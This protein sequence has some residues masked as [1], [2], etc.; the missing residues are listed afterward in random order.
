M[1]AL[2]LSLRCT[3]LL[4]RTMHKVV[5][6]NISPM[7]IREI[8]LNEQKADGGDATDNAESSVV[9]DNESEGECDGQEAPENNQDDARRYSVT[10]AE[11]HFDGGRSVE[12]D[13]VIYSGLDD[14]EQEADEIESDGESSKESNWIESDKEMVF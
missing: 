13:D 12:E 2:E 4:M 6:T 10:E 14:H 1:D 5:Y 9:K 3:G 7:N 8:Q 11:K